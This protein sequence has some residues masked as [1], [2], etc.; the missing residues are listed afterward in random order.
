MKAKAPGKLVI[1]GAYS[2]LKGAP[3][4]VTAVDRYV[5]A[6]DSQTAHFETPEVAQALKLMGSSKP[7]PAFNA[8]AL[9]EGGRKLGLGSS[10]AICASSVALLSRTNAA[11]LED[12]LLAESIYNLVL[13]AHREAQGGG[14]GIDVAAACFGGT[15]GA[16]L[17]Q[18]HA[19]RLLELQTVN[20][21]SALVIE[22]W[23]S[24][25]AAT[26]SEFVRRVFALEQSEPERFTDLM[27]RQIEASERALAAAIDNNSTQFIVALK[28]QFQALSALGLAAAVPIVLTDI[29]QLAGRLADDECLIP[30][31]AGGG[32]IT[33]FIAT[34]PSSEDFRKRAEA[35]G[36]KLV[37]LCLSARGVHLLA[38]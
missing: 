38:H 13:R 25:K 15:L 34:R 21:P 33:L 29:A 17:A 35:L 26:T 24:P 5:L 36:Q 37:P 23:A 32:D 10:A 20:L 2:V 1:S 12:R 16:R 22:T 30:S 8:D 7:H 27:G 14:S 31:G 28:A 11:K 19:E 3:A 4:L 9:R 6:D 18:D